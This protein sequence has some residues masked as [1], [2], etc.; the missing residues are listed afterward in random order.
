MHKTEPPANFIK[1]HV[2]MHKAILDFAVSCKECGVSPDKCLSM[3]VATFFVM[4]NKKDTPA[5]WRRDICVQAINDAL[6]AMG[7]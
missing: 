1:T 4:F 3:I 7:E 2:A 5:K 6:K